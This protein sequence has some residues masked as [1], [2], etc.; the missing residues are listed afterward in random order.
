MPR[1]A[2]SNPPATPMAA[3]SPVTPSYPWRAPVTFPGPVTQTTPPAGPTATVPAVSGTTAPGT[4]VIPVPP[5]EAPTVAPAKVFPA[6]PVPPVPA[7]VAPVV[8]PSKPM[9]PPPPP[10]PVWEARQGESLQQV[11][12]RWSQ[13]AGYKVDWRAEDLDYPIDA[14][15]RFQGSYE[16]AV[17]SIF[18]LYQ[19]ADRPF[20]VDGRRSQHRLI[21]N[22]DLDSTRRAK[23]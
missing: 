13:T 10:K 18:K 1:R 6:T 14:P 20:D 2:L 9:P 3:T 15:L 23:K 12:K 4:P 7:V 17:L 19:H 11:I 5:R 16:E 21:V 8:T 22:E